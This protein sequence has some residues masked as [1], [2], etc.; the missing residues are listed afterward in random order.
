MKKII[1]ILL[2]VSA[3]ACVFTG[4]GE[5]TTQGQ[6]QSTISV[7]KATLLDK[8][9]VSLSVESITEARGLRYVLDL[10]M[11][12]K[13]TEAIQVELDAVSINGLTIPFEYDLHMLDKY[14]QEYTSK[15]LHR[16]GSGTLRLNLDCAPLF[17]WGMDKLETI[18]FSLELKTTYSN[19]KVPVTIPVQMEG[20]NSTLTMDG[21]KLLEHDGMT[22]YYKV[23]EHMPVFLLHNTSDEKMKLNVEDFRVNNYLI[24]IGTFLWFDTPYEAEPGQ[25]V[26][27][28]AYFPTG[29]PQAKADQLEISFCMSVKKDGQ[30]VFTDTVSYQTEVFDYGSPIDDNFVSLVEDGNVSI[31]V[32]TF[33]W[34]GYKEKDVCLW[35]R[36]D[37]DEPVTVEVYGVSID[38]RKLEDAKTADF[39]GQYYDYQPIEIP[40]HC[41]VLDGITHGGSGTPEMYGGIKEASILVCLTWED[42]WHSTSVQGW[43]STVQFQ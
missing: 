35:I 24:D 18:E 17:Q 25:T 23:Y 22:L 36:N 4:C 21:T 16:N 9:Y 43:N 33:Q 12:N 42:H 6:A 15:T 3:L 13:G 27:A 14:Q 31:S 39:E 10:S 26:V 40:P 41:Q 7:E 34:N 5:E 28:A 2:V 30:K 38:G 37:G 11:T 19:D 8:P 20:T 32:G 1:S 29:F